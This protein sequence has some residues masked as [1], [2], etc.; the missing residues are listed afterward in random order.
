MNTKLSVMN[1]EPKTY[2]V[3]VFLY[4]SKTFDKVSVSLLLEKCKKYE[5]DSKTLAEVKDQSSGHS[6]QVKVSSVLPSDSPILSS[7]PQVSL[8]WIQCYFV[9]Q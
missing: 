3:K 1:P 4:F 9:C 2:S 6:Q 5:L 7:R 8:Y